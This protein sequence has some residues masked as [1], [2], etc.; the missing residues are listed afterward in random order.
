[1]DDGNLF[2]T[3]WWARNGAISQGHYETLNGH[4]CLDIVH[5]TVKNS[6]GKTW[7]CGI[8]RLCPVSLFQTIVIEQVIEDKSKSTAVEPPHMCMHPPPP[9]HPTSTRTHARLVLVNT[10]I[11]LRA[12]NEE[13]TTT[14]RDRSADDV[15]D[16]PPGESRLHT[17][18]GNWND[19]WLLDAKVLRHTDAAG[20][21]AW[22]YNTDHT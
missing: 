2:I 20:N 8:V 9:P 14:T 19:H 11:R 10:A 4:F 15:L 3:P 17:L 7:E 5:R 12:L 21:L 18:I 1:M 6:R 22:T 13:P 16:R